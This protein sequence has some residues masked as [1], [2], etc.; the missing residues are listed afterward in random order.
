[1]TFFQVAGGG[2]DKDALWR[3]FF[4]ENHEVPQTASMST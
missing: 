4:L 1:M 3:G 2:G